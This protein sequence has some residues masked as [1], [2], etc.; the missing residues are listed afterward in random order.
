M[1]IHLHYEGQHYYYFDRAA[2]NGANV[3][4]DDAPDF[5][6]GFKDWYTSDVALDP[7][8]FYYTATDR[9][10]PTYRLIDDMPDWFLAGFDVAGLPA[11]VGSEEK[12]A[13]VCGVIGLEVYHDN[14]DNLIIKPL[15]PY[16]AHYEYTKRRV[17]IEGEWLHREGT[18]PPVAPFE[19][20]AEF[21]PAVREFAELHHL[22]PCRVVWTEA[23]KKSLLQDIEQ[24]GGEHIKNAYCHDDIAIFWRADGLPM[25]RMAFPTLKADNLDALIVVYDEWHAGLMEHIDRYIYASE[26]KC[27]MCQGAGYAP[28]IDTVRAD[29]ALEELISNLRKYGQGRGA[30]RDDARR[31]LLHSAKKL[32]ALA[33]HALAVEQIDETWV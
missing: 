14:W 26:H 3:Q 4:H 23:H 30:K 1:N 18:A 5:V 11:E 15:K 19:W 27:P 17:A 12:M 16:E 9:E 33:V 32:H 29:D 7:D 31:D 2:T 22:F 8:G 10:D 6:R 25:S 28:P 21:P 20:R 24:R 13:A